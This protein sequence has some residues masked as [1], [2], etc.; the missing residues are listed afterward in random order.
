VR[1]VTGLLLGLLLVG[2]VLTEVPIAQTEPPAVAS[3]WK[4]T[5]NGWEQANSWLAP[6]YVQHVSLHPAVVGALELFLSVAA[7]VGLSLSGR[8]ES[9]E[10]GCPGGDPC[11]NCPHRHGRGHHAAV[12]HS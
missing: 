5:V 9:P 7:L 11:K 4:R 12:S 1:R 10:T 3:A 2:W 8:Q 6:P